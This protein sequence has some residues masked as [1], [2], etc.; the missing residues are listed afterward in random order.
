VTYIYSQSEGTLTRDGQEIGIGYSGWDEPNGL[1]G[2]NNPALQEDIG[3]GPIPQGYW[4]IGQPYDSQSHGP[5]VMSLT[6]L[7]ATDT[8]GRTAFLMHGDAVDPARAGD[9]SRGCIIL[10]RPV[11]DEVSSNLETDNLLEVVA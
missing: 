2:K 11:R 7:A 5:R 1:Q 10:S 8:F 4:R 6:P 3:V 9:A